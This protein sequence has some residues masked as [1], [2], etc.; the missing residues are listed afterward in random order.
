MVDYSKTKIYRITF[1]NMSYYGHTTQP[2]SKRRNHH[3]EDFKKHPN[4]KVYKAM[5][6]AGMTADDIELI[7]VE[8]YP[9]ETKEQAKSRERF[10]IENF[11]TLNCRLPYKEGI[12]EQE[13]K[14]EYYENNRDKIFAYK[15]EYRENNRDELNAK[16]REYY[17]NNRDERL[18]K[19]RKN[20]ENNREE[21]NAKKREYHKN[22]REEIN[23]KKCEYMR[24]YRA[25]KK[26][27]S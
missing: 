3:K 15:R 27:T 16:K 18:A 1:N 22:N 26:L 25:R 9:C 6:K 2:L 20:Y 17:E 7:W 14:R 8:D 12:T 23:A 19:S 13:Y 21:I 5:R 24:E 11:G 10:Y 4:Q